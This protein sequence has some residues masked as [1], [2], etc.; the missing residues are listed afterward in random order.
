MVRYS[1]KDNF[2]VRGQLCRRHI[3]GLGIVTGEYATSGTFLGD[4]PIIHSTDGLRHSYNPELV[5]MEPA[6]PWERIVI[7]FELVEL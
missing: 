2:L 4:W 1:F 5:R 6:S 3:V 7:Q